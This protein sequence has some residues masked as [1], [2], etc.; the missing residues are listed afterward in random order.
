[1]ARDVGTV[2]VDLNS[3]PAVVV[4]YV[5]GVGGVIGLALLVDW[6]LTRRQR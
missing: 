6:M 5:I 1:M 3:W 2:S 4:G